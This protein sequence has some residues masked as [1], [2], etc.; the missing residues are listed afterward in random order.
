MALCAF[1][2]AKNEN[3]KQNINKK[4]FDQFHV[5]QVNSIAASHYLIILNYKNTSTYFELLFFYTIITL[6]QSSH[7][8]LNDNMLYNKAIKVR[9]KDHA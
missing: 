2:W 8:N 3:V 7:Q 4:L 9:W 5:I 1:H 6:S